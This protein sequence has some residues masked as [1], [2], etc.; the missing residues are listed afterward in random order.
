MACNVLIPIT[1]AADRVGDVVGQVGGQVQDAVLGSMGKEMAAAFDLLLKDVMTSWLSLGATTASSS[2]TIAW[3]GAA[4][5]TIQTTLVVVGLII[6]GIRTML[7]AR[8]EPLKQVSVKLFRVLLVAGLGEAAILMLD[9]AGVAFAVWILREAGIGLDDFGVGLVVGA[10]LSSPAVM[11]IAGLVGVLALLFQW[12]IMLLRSVILPVLRAFW[13]ISAAA[14]MV[15]E[16]GESSFS[17]VTA[18]LVAWILYVPMAGALYAFG[19]HEKSNAESVGEVLN[20]MALIILVSFLLPAL[21]RLLM[22][23]TERMG[24]AFGGSAAAGAVTGAVAAGV[25]IGAVAMTGGA[26]T[27]AGGAT[28]GGVTTSGGD[29]AQG[30]PGNAGSPGPQGSPSAPGADGS[31]GADGT[32]AGGSAG[33]GGSRWV[34]AAAGSHAMSAG[35]SSADGSEVIGG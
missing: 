17:K 11:L 20:G 14:A 8:G 19:W 29:V 12:A 32:A 35:G 10:S 3:F 9:L 24:S 27:A 26:S 18:W 34:E 28:G 16:H 22:P 30:S 1:C 25:A 2:G 13:P 21:L 23:V 31:A 15:G 6:A 7:S 33:G 4:I 5:A